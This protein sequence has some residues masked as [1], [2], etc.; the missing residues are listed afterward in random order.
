MIMLHLLGL[1]SLRRLD[2][3]HLDGNMI[4]GSKLRKS[5]RAFSS[6][7]MLSMRENEFKGTIVP[8]GN[9]YL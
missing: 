9:K 2:A 8:G 6:V 1:K 4:D 5:L 3:L 7:R